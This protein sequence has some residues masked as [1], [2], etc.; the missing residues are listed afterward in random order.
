MKYIKLFEDI[1]WNWDEEEK[2]DINLSN[3]NPNNIL[4]FHKDKWVDISK[5]LDEFGYK[6]I[7]GKSIFTSK[8][9]RV[10][11][12]NFIILINYNKKISFYSDSNKSD[13]DKN[14]IIEL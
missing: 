13:F 4:I 10:N 11:D 12:D 2:E 5:K 14:Q 6:W 3:L 1:D 8:P 7:S 9:Y